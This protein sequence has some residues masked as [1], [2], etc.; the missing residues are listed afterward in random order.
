MKSLPY[1]VLPKTTTTAKITI[2]NKSPELSTK[3]VTH[4]SEFTTM[5]VKPYQ[6]MGKSIRQFLASHA[7]SSFEVF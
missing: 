7:C 1:V 4:V 2:L 3:E 6:N 5:D